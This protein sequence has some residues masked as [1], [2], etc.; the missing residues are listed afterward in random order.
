MP[1]RFDQLICQ[2]APIATTYCPTLEIG[3]DT[4]Y[5]HA[6]D[7]IDD[8]Q[9][10]QAYVLTAFNYAKGD[11]WGVEF[12]GKF[13]AGNLS[14]ATNWAVANQL[15]TT[16]VSNQSLFPGPDELAYAATHWIHTDHD[17]WLTGSGRV[18]Y[19]WNDTHT[20]WDGT[21]MSATMIYGSGLRTG[22]ANTGSLPAYWQVN[23]GVSHEFLPPPNWTFNKQPIT[24]RFDVVNITDNIYQIRN[25]SGI[26]VFAPQYG[27]RRGYFV[28]ISQKLGPT[29]VAPGLATPLPGIYK[30]QPAQAPLANWTG[31]YGGAHFGG[32]F[33]SGEDEFVAPA[34]L[35]TP[36]HIKTNPSGAL[37]GIQLGYN[38]IASPN[39]LTGVEWEFSWTTAQ[40]KADFFNNVTAAALTSSHKW[41]DS[42]TGR[43]A[44]ISTARN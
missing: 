20:W 39:W 29:G 15:A 19:R 27:P 42:L 35:G 4:Y 22:F 44:W 32:A 11:N 5:K 2:G 1:G 28:G 8:G 7:L 17:Q 31:F 33:S 3:I 14:I 21:L 9:F 16:V 12:S 38:Y 10:G 41:Y 13:V 18:A 34:L 37:G 25:G 26:G 23:V 43:L 6:K 24:V 40:G 36:M 30:A